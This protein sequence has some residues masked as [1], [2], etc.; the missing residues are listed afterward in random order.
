[1]NDHPS[2]QR[3]PVQQWSSARSVRLI[4]SAH[5][6]GRKHRTTSG[7]RYSNN[8]LRG[9]GAG[10]CLHDCVTAG[11]MRSALSITAAAHPS[12]LNVGP[13]WKA[14]DGA[15]VASRWRRGRAASEGVHGGGAHRHRRR[16]GNSKLSSPTH[17]SSRASCRNQSSRSLAGRPR[18]PDPRPTS[19]RI[20]FRWLGS[21]SAQS[22]PPRAR[23]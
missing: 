11:S 13:C 22:R 9:A 14:Q 21:G 8:P 23:S 15:C 1:M 10:A 16:T 12:V 6:S 20:R 19:G 18:C 5:F 17:R 2:Q 3:P 7:C 4:T